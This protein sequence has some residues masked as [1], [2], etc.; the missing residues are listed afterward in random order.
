LHSTSEHTS[1]HQVTLENIVEQ[2]FATTGL[3]CLCLACA[4]IDACICT[5]ACARKFPCAYDSGSEIIINVPNIAS[6]LL[7][8]SYSVTVTVKTMTVIL[9]VALKALRAASVMTV[10]ATAT[11]TVLTVKMTTATVT[12]K[13]YTLVQRAIQTRISRGE[14][15]AQAAFLIKI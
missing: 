15:G 1:E 2:I 8:S 7:S 9:M 14:R 13:V 3:P 4:C 11:V 6:V 12:G 10:S 5:Y